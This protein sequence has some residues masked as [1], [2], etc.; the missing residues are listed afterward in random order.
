MPK[1]KSKRANGEGSFYQSPDKSWVHQITLG[2]KP[3]GSLNRKTFKAKT[4]TACI[5]RRDAYFADMQQ[6]ESQAREEAARAAELFSEQ[7]KRGYAIESET[8]FSEAFPHWLKLFKAPPTKK[9]STY[10][11]YLNT[12]DAHFNEF[13][14]SMRLHEITRD[15][16]QGYYNAKQMNGSRKDGKAGALSAKTI[17]NHHMILRDFFD[18]AVDRYKL[19]ANPAI[20]TERPEV[21][22]P[23]MRVLESGEMSVFLHEVMRE[24]QRTAI[25]FALFMGLRVGEL[26][27]TEVDDINLKTQSLRVQRNITRVSTVAIDPGNPQIRVL[28]Y[29]PAKKTHLIVQETPKTKT[30]A[31][32][33]PISDSVFT[34]LAK[35]LYYLQQSGWPNPH[36][37]LFPSTTGSYIDPKSFDLRLKAVSKRCEIKKVNP[38]ALRH[39]FATRLVEEAVPLTTIQRLMG[40]ASVSTTERYVTTMPEE[41]RKAVESM[42]VYCD[43]VKLIE[44]KKLNGTKP[45]MQYSDVRLPTWLQIEPAEAQTHT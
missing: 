43:P 5:E 39:T 27:A 15:V 1:Q 42:A 26:L 6:R 44:A 33:I 22:R 14:G 7:T 34:L 4:R 12:Y 35:H 17:R 10:T 21:N 19:P 13:F 8:L 28:N 18:Y 16:V 24:T 29:N 31:R 32:S 38:H 23:Q 40:H 30:S 3:D 11:G 45:R 2:R 20:K 25:L 9:A 41:M 36:N 37:L